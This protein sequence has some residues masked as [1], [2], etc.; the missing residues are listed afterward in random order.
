MEPEVQ[1]SIGH[2]TLERWRAQELPDHEAAALRTHV[3][4]CP[5]CSERLAAL[6]TDQ[7]AFEVEIP[8]STFQAEH[9]RRTERRRVR[10]LYWGIPA[11]G[12][13]A[14]LAWVMVPAWM[15]E[16]K[17]PT[18]RLKGSEV[19][20]RFDILEEGRARPGMSGASIQ[21]DTRIRLHYQIPQSGYLGLFSRRQS[22]GTVS[23]L[24][25]PAT[26]GPRKAPP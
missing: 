5:R 12:L 21:P 2:H 17:A 26:S 10:P 22:A 20:L 1:C 19:Q 4:T 18:V 9:Q 13:S 14:T 11:L 15:A 23:R 3:P 25:P 6:E 7:A 16:P 24:Y 8:F